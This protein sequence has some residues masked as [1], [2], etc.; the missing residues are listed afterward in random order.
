MDIFI[1]YT[2]KI[3][4][5]PDEAL[6]ALLEITS[7]VKYNKK[8]DLIKIGEIN[9]KFCFILEGG[10]KKFAVAKDSLKEIIIQ[11]AFSGE[12]ACSLKSL[13]KNKP[14]KVGC[15]A[16][17]DCF[18]LEASIEKVNQ[19]RIQY[20]DIRELMHKIIE[21]ELTNLQEAYE[22]LL[23][24]D[25]TQRYLILKGKVKNIDQLLP[26]YQ[27]ASLLGIT[28]IQLSRISKKLLTTSY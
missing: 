20:S 2:E 16:I 13:T 14:S 15:K 7:L 26:Q 11:T 8:D 21:L 22:Q 10:V 18:V 24:K 27:I 6:K 25:A 28:P 12:I 19:L 3:H 4:P 1:G 9:D 17:T 5:L 23:T